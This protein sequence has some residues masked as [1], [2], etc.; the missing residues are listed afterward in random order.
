V[1]VCVYFCVCV[2][3]CI[4]VAVCVCMC[5]S[6]CDCLLYVEMGGFFEREIIYMCIDRDRER[7]S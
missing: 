6:L 5:G 2:C 3:V 4:C 7:E 1:C